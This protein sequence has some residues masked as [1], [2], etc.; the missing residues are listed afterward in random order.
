MAWTG[1][2]RS[3]RYSASYRL[4]GE[5]YTIKGTFTRRADALAEAQRERGSKRRGE[6]IDPELSGQTFST[7]AE[8]Y[9]AGA[10]PML[11]GK[12]VASYESLLSSRI[13]PTFGEYEL[14]SILPSDITTWIGSMVADGLSPSRIRQAHVVLRLV[15]DSAV[16]DGYLARNPAVGAEPL[17]VPWT[18]S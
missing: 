3:G 1:K 7:R 6:F 2:Q 15:L 16:R 18:V 8:S 4:Q 9:L 10:R 17:P 14:R 5:D 13:L 12:T 11:K